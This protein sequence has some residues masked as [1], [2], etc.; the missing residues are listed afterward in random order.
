ME[1]TENERTDS[2]DFSV[3]QN[4]LLELK[5]IN[6]AS[7]NEFSM[8]CH[9]SNFKIYRN[10]LWG[11]KHCLKAWFTDKSPVS[12]FKELYGG[13]KQREHCSAI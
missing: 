7:K 9:N 10:C 8:Y 1:A 4:P 6:P 12:A 5:Q 11:A 3:F 13:I 2:G